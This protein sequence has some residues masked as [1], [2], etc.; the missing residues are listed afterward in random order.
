M[1]PQGRCGEDT[2]ERSHRLHYW[3]SGKRGQ[4][5]ARAGDGSVERSAFEP[6][7]QPT[8]ANGH[9]IA[10]PT[11][12]STR[13]TSRVIRRALSTFAHDRLQSRQVNCRDFPKLLVVEALVLVPQDVADSDNG[14]PWCIRVFGEV[15]QRQC[16]RSLRNDLYGT[17]YCGACSLPWYCANES[18]R[19]IMATPSIS[20][21]I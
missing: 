21:R 13:S 9:A 11:T 2:A 14:S 6:V 1:P 16:F 17:F 10:C 19:T 15:I 12:G 5:N 7:K 3:M 20:S 18:P 4:S 8:R